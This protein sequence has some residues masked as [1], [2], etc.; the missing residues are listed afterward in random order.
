MRY[1]PRQGQQNENSLPL[2]SIKASFWNSLKLNQQHAPHP[3][4]HFSNIVTFIQKLN[5]NID[6]NN[7]T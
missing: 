3:M 1:I 6:K 7:Y 2:D 5:Y 4:C